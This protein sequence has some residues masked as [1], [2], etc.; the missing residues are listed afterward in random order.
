MDIPIVYRVSVCDRGYSTV[1]KA[2][3]EIKKIY[4][5]NSKKE[6]LKYVKYLLKKYSDI[7]ATSPYLQRKMELKQ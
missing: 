6:L 4:L 1:R 5:Y 2:I 7:V 3:R